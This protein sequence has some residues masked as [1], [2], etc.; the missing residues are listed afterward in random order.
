M[1]RM[2]LG[3]DE[4]TSDIVES[5]IV[6]WKDLL[7][8]VR[9]FHFGRNS[10]REDF[11][12]VWS[13]R[14]GTCSSKHAFLKLVAELN[15]FENVELCIAIYRM[16]S[17]NTPEIRKILEKKDL[18][19]IPEVYCYLKIDGNELDVTT[20]KSDFNNY[21]ADIIEEFVIE[22]EAVVSKKI[23]LHKNFIK[24]WIETEQISHLLSE[25]WELREQC[26]LALEKR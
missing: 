16:N 4:L 21:K 9:Q 13:E 23:D 26:I 6:D 18:S 11:T 22:K 3:T 17:I 10:N 7:R 14:K 2:L 25:I 15:G 5:G 12:L 8:T 19:Y 24:N 1:E 20:L